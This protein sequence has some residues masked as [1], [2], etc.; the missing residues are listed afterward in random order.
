M[1][2]M[3]PREQFGRNYAANLAAALDPRLAYLNRQLGVYRT[4]E[5]IASEVGG[6]YQPAIARA[7]QI[8]QDVAAVGQT[9]LAAATG[10]A[11]ALPNFDV[12]ALA[13][14]ARA[15]G[16]AGGTAA[17]T[18]SVME[19]QARAAL[20]QSIMSEQARVTE[21]RTQTEREIAG[22]E[23]EKAKIAAD[24]MAPAMQRQQMTTTALQNQQIRAELRNVPI[25]RRA[26]RLQNM[27]LRGQIRG[28][29]LENAATV[30]ELKKLGLTDKQIKKLQGAGATTASA[31][32]EVAE[33]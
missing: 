30:A 10:L 24:W 32:A 18:G 3:A 29:N 20:A 11:S 21:Q 31:D 17:L 27:L 1:A 6:L 22:S 8:G 23:E 25:A 26:A 15:T 2:E 9:G 7:G 16:R 4:P 12:A 14:A 28:V 13:D 5:Q 19:S 33:T